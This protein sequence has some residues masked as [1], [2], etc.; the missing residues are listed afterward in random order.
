MTIPAPFPPTDA[1]TE[2]LRGVGDD[3]QDRLV[4]AGVELHLPRLNSVFWAW[5]RCLPLLVRN[6]QPGLMSHLPR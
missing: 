2:W 1:C 6:F 4:E 5:E 3:L